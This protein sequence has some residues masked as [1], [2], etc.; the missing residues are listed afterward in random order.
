MKK[1]YKY[2][3]LTM[4]TTGT[5]FYSCE[6]TE[7]DLLD[8]PNT[9]SPEQGSVELFL[10]AMELSFAGFVENITEASAEVTRIKHMFGPTYQTAYSPAFFNGHWSIYSSFM[11]DS[12]AMVPLA[13]DQG[14]FIHS[15]IAKVLEAYIMVTLVDNFGDVPYTEAL[16]ANILNPNVDSGADIYAAMYT[17][18]NEAIADFNKVSVGSPSRD[19]FYGG[20][21]S[22]WI[23]F[24]NSLKLKMYLTTGLVNSG[25]TAAINSLIAGGNLISS[26]A[27][28]MEFPWAT[29]IVSPDSRHPKYGNNYDNA[30]SSGDYMSTYFMYN[31]VVQK[32]ITDPRSRYYFYRQVDT[33][34]SDVNE[35]SCITKPKPGHY[36]ITDPYCNIQHPGDSDGYW[37]RDHGNADGI[38]P[39]GFLKTTF[40]LYPIGGQYDADQAAPVAQ[41]LGGVGAG[42]SPVILTSYVHFMRAAAA[43]E[44]GTSDDARVQLEAG[45][46]ASMAKVTGFLPGV[47]RGGFDATEAAD[48]EIYVTKVLTDAVS[49]YDVASAAGKL[50]IV[51]KEYY[52]ALFGNGME[53]FNNYRRT[54]YPSDLQPT[55]L[56]TPGPFIRSFFY[57]SS[58]VDVNS[59]VSQKADVTTRVFWDTNSDP[60]N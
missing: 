14:L 36:A 58:F 31:M 24:A 56:A 17:L 35:Q 54:G 32:N 30:S 34:T 28:D 20:D 42:I 25:S 26:E 8:S 2:L 23:K 12:R 52:L 48:I 10:N 15:G 9:L 5:L 13:E 43:L 44:L 19:L 60:L 29:N 49:G 6:T 4:L 50:E 18:I 57:P 41:T 3:L 39:D 1:I 7:L 21:T 47:S 33:N 27:D 51:I 16:D 40:G 46:R 11:A 37:G 53:A 22:K 55:I 45:I 59:V 38:P